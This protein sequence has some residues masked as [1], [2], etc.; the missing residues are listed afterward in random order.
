MS[1]LMSHN[2]V[3]QIKELKSYFK[4]K[5]GYLT[6]DKFRV[7]I[8]DTDLERRSLSRRTAV[9]IAYILEMWRGNVGRK[10]RIHLFS[11]TRGT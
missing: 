6:W 1:N 9:V 3:I 11:R 8:I 7:T 10:F 4:F 2:Y 5:S